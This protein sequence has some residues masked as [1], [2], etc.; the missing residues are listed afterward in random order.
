MILASVF[1]HIAVSWPLRLEPPNDGMAVYW[2]RI[3]RAFQISVRPCHWN[4]TANV[5]GEIRLETQKSL[6]LF[7]DVYTQNSKVCR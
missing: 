5:P 3:F 4:V 7:K 6:S 2:K 1:T